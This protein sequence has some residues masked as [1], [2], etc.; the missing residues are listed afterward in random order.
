MEDIRLGHNRDITRM[1]VNVLGTL[2]YIT[3]C[4][5]DAEDVKKAR[6][7]IGGTSLMPTY[8]IVTPGIDCSSPTTGKYASAAHAMADAARNERSASNGVLCG[9]PTTIEIY[10]GDWDGDADPVM[11]RT[12]DCT[13]RVPKCDSPRG[14]NWQDRSPPGTGVPGY[15]DQRAVCSR[16]SLVRRIV[17]DSDPTGKADTVSYADDIE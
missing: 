12:I 5:V 4:G 3:D 13:P 10:A 11:E 7:A 2:K 14:H 15:D 1:R 8:T 9:G 16:C 6:K 17:G